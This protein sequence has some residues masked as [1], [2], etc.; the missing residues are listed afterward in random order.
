ME[1]TDNKFKLSHLTLYA[2]GW[3]KQTDDI[4]DDL[5]K[6]LKLDDYTPFSKQDVYSI[7]LTNVSGFKQPWT[8][9]YSVLKNIQSN[10]CW[11]YGYVT[12]DAPTILKSVSKDNVKV[13][14][15]EEAFIWY[16]LSNLRTLENKYWN[17]VTPKFTKYPKDPDITIKECVEHFGRKTI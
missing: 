3:Y 14:S 17:P 8:S 1:Q 9:L 10:V 13:Y 15:M 2:K 16:V 5:T 7:I 11:S 12:E 6:I 4:W